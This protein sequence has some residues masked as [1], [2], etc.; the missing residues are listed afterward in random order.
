VPTG[1]NLTTVP[2]IREGTEEEAF[3]GSAGEQID[4]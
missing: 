1:A 4:R 3:G 2:T